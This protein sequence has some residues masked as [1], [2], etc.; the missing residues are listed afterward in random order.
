MNITRF[1]KVT[2]T[3]TPGGNESAALAATTLGATEVSV[4]Q[5][6]QSPGGTNPNH[7]HDREEIMLQLVGQSVVTVGGTEVV[8]E[9]GDT[10]MIPSATLHSIENRGSLTAEWLIISRHD[11]GFFKEDRTKIQPSWAAQG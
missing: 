5:Q 4:I 2:F 9:P 10:L 8:L 7:F 3:A 6:R 1:A 11:V